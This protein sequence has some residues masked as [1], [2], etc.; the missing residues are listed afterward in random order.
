M[1]RWRTAERRRDIPGDIITFGETFIFVS[2]LCHRIY[3]Q[4]RTI[5][6]TSQALACVGRGEGT[7]SLMGTRALMAGNEDRI[8]KRQD[9][10]CL[11]CD[12]TFQV[13]RAESQRPSRIAACLGRIF[14]HGTVRQVP[15]GCLLRYSSVGA[16]HIRQRLLAHQSG[17]SPGIY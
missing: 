13:R 17:A 9:E 12:T 8:N 10:T 7:E 14:L 2:V 11:A 1:A 15:I 3:D 4:T 16:G 6:L 5:C